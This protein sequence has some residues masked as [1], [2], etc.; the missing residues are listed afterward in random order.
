MNDYY[1]QLLLTGRPDRLNQIRE[2][3][4]TYFSEDQIEEVI[5][6]ETAHPIRRLGVEYL[7][8]MIESFK[9]DHN[10]YYYLNLEKW[11]PIVG[12]E[13]NV[14]LTITNE[15]RL[16]IRIATGMEPELDKIKERSA[17]YPEVAFHYHQLRGHMVGENI[18]VIVNGKIIDAI[19]SEVE[20]TEHDDLVITYHKWAFDDEQSRVRL[21]FETLNENGEWEM[22]PLRIVD[23]SM[24][25]PGCAHDSKEDAPP[26]V[27]VY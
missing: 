8:N 25:Y 23:E 1:A 9:D 15:S 10:G 18:F 7:K 20:Y 26:V 27:Y 13:A 4:F 22:G 21:R 3:L 5:R 17:Q 24:V 6:Q 14:D 16:T 11:E 19:W 2:E 12:P